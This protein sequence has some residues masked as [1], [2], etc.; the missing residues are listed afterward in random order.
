H[1]CEEGHVHDLLELAGGVRFGQRGGGGARRP[2]AHRHVIRLEERLE[3]RQGRGD[4]QAHGGGPSGDGFGQRAA[5]DSSSNAEEMS[6]PISSTS[7]T[8]WRSEVKPQKMVP[9]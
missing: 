3:H 6:S 8:A 5:L 7:G 4:E 2:T 1:G 9:A